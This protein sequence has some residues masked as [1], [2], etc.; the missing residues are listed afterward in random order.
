VAILTLPKQKAKPLSK[1]HVSSLKEKR[2]PN[3][4]HLSFQKGV[5]TNH[6]RLKRLS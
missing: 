3:K 6:A 4:K 2:M 5:K 1:K